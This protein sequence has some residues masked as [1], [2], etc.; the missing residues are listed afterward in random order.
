MTQTDN[1]TFIISDTH[2]SHENILT[3]NREDGQKVRP[4]FSSF[5]EMDEYIV[6]KWNSVVK[7]QD[8]VYHLG[9]VVMKKRY[10]DVV[11]R[12]NGRKRLIMGN[13]DIFG[14]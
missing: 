7:P 12:L 3:F 4:G 6:N 8:K 9:D 14:L 5:E 1:N 13:H 10:I 2:F 11:K